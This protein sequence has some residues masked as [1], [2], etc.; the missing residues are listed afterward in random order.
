MHQ[1]AG[2]ETPG[3]RWI[4]RCVLSTTHEPRKHWNDLLL[5]IGIEQFVADRR[6]DERADIDARQRRSE[7]V[8]IVAPRNAVAGSS[9]ISNGR[10]SACTKLATSAVWGDRVDRQRGGTSFAR[11]MTM[12]A[13]A[14]HLWQVTTGHAGLSGGQLASSSRGGRNRLGQTVQVCT[15]SDQPAWHVSTYDRSRQSPRRSGISPS[16][17]RWTRALG[18]LVAPCD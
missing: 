9:A 13:S 10:Y 12:S 11:P 18:S 7:H 1:G 5:L 15:L 14:P 3:R 17:S 4:G 2:R 16:Y 6:H 8:R